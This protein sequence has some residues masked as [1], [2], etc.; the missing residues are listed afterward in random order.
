MAIGQAH[1][2]AYRRLG[3]AHV[4]LVIEWNKPP[5][6]FKPIDSFPL[7]YTTYGIGMRGKGEAFMPN[8]PDDFKENVYLSTKATLGSKVPRRA[9]VRLVQSEKDTLIVYSYVDSSVDQ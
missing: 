3:C 6:I 1:Q 4:S 5:G 2:E 9:L 8:L 7:P